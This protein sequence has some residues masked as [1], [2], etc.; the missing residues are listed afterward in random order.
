MNCS[1]SSPLT[2][3]L[4]ASS[5]S[6]CSSPLTKRPKRDPLHAANSCEAINH[7][8]QPQPSALPSLTD[9]RV[10]AMLGSRQPLM[11]TFQTVMRVSQ[12]IFALWEGRRHKSHSNDSDGNSSSN[13]DSSSDS[14][15]SNSNN[16]SSPR[17]SSCAYQRR[18]HF[19]NYVLG[20]TMRS[21]P[22]AVT[23]LHAL[24]YVL[25]LRSAYPEAR[26]QTGCATRMFVVALLVAAKYCRDPHVQVPPSYANW[27]V[28]SGAF[29]PDELQNM[30]REFLLFIRGHVTV[31]LGELEWLIERYFVQS[32]QVDRA[33]PGSVDLFSMICCSERR[34]HAQ[35][36]QYSKGNDAV[37]PSD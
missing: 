24:L 2:G 7:Q 20:F 12:I 19:I 25:R 27:S 29:S 10:A 28:L 13:S 14:S 26:G 18:L 9:G 21:G 17:N 5:S 1:L 37:C 3:S 15:P 6:P 36:V 30:E 8:Q 31:Q 16:P 11:P 32:E 34:K 4:P 22:S 35:D 23:L 33:V